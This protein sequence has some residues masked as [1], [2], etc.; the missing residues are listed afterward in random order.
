[1]AFV[2]LDR[3]DR[4]LRLVFV[5]LNLIRQPDSDEALIVA[6]P[7]STHAFDRTLCEQAG[8]GRIDTAA[9]PEDQRFHARFAQA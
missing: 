7:C 1:M 8:G 4:Q 3:V 9:D 2:R 6:L 5:M